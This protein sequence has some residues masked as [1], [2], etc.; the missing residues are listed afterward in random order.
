M[1]QA[2]TKRDDKVG[3]RIYLSDLPEELVKDSIVYLPELSTVQKKHIKYVSKFTLQAT[4]DIVVKLVRSDGFD[5]FGRPKALAHNIVLSSEEYNF[6]SLDYYA[7][8]L[9]YSDFFD[10][11]ES[12]PQLLP[13]NAFVR[14]EN[15]I[16]EK[17]DL[18]TL[19]EIIVSA[20]TQSKVIL[21]PQLDVEGLIELASVIDKAI[22]YEASY[23]F[24]LISYSD[25][26]C[27]KKLVHS[28]LY[29]FSTDTKE[30]NA[31]IKIKN[32]DSKVSKITSESKDFLDYYI[33]LIINRDYEKLLEEHAK[34][35]IGMYHN[36]YKSLQYAFT[37]RYQLDM[38]FSR[39]N[40]FQ[41]KLVKYLSSFG[42]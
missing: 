33:E 6:N 8:P 26:T 14:K 2:V 42:S 39:R 18:G 19:R 1:Y 11:I 4:G 35:V 22:P 38:P 36:E 10:N 30:H 27:A 20:M 15:K 7:S 29:L 32:K 16:L 40:M 37:K 31:D 21:Q 41:A 5:P 12:D 17:L 9:V 3:Y 24:S 23:D 13:E 25:E 28:V 34:L